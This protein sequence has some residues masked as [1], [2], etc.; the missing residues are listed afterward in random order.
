MFT[1]HVQ[2][3]AAL[4]Q[5][6]CASWSAAR[7]CKTP[8]WQTGGGTEWGG[9]R[10]NP[11]AGTRKASFS[12]IEKRLKRAVSMETRIQFVPGT[13]GWGTEPRVCSCTDPGS[14][15]AGRCSETQRSE[16]KHTG[17][18][19]SVTLTEDYSDKRVQ[20][21]CIYWRES[22]GLGSYRETALEFPSFK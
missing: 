10:W 2:W 22:E 21:K 13:S 9:T 1:P 15:P 5:T 12:R 4:T 19:L 11:A 18:K 3:G 16:V 20:S 14:A 6:H 17:M 8:T 7:L